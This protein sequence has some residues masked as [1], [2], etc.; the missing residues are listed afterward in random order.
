MNEEITYLFT[1]YRN[2]V[3]Y[4]TNCKELAYVRT[5]EPDNIVAHQIY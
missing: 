3:E 1:Y 4:T 2:S 5:D